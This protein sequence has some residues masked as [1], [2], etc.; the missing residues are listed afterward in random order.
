MFE[1]PVL[2]ATLGAALRLEAG[3]RVLD[4]GSDIVFLTFGLIGSK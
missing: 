1:P 3:T 4:L 2:L